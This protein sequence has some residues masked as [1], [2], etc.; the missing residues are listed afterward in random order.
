MKIRQMFFTVFLLL[1]VSPVFVQGANW[2]SI[3]GM[4]FVGDADIIMHKYEGISSYV[5]LETTIGFAWAPVTFPPNTKGKEVIRMEAL[6][7]DGLD[8]K[9]G[10]LDV[11]NVGISLHKVDLDTGLDTVVMSTGTGYSGAP[12]L[13]TLSTKQA[14][15]PQIDNKKWSWYIKFRVELPSSS[16]Y[17]EM[18]LYGVRI[19]Y[20]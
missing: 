12:G 1:I 8:V 18:R 2:I 20:K 3:S 9:Y 10:I 16:Q 14:T 4:T 7:Y 13:I 6:I 17:D 15:D 19:R 11:A 5:T